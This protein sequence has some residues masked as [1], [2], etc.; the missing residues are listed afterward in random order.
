MAYDTEEIKVGTLD[1][2]DISTTFRLDLVGYGS[3]RYVN[4]TRSSCA[5]VSQTSSRRKT[6]QP[7]AQLYGSASRTFGS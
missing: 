7:M 4:T 2:H 3:R 6:V 5:Y 1:E